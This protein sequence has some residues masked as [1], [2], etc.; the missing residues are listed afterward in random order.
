M[1]TVAESMRFNHYR[2]GGGEDLNARVGAAPGSPRLQLFV[3]RRR[4]PVAPL[5][6]VP[7]V[8]TP[9]ST[10]RTSEEPVTGEVAREPVDEEMLARFIR[11]VAR[12]AAAGSK[13][14]QRAYLHATLRRLSVFADD[15]R[16]RLTDPERVAA[17]LEEYRPLL[18][19]RQI[20]VLE[21]WLKD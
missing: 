12:Y 7:Q 20:K 14:H 3:E 18:Q 17:A 6:A 10:V 19:E 8:P 16:V 9:V 4:A 13:G 15:E 21:N 11:T 1:A 5:V 2:L